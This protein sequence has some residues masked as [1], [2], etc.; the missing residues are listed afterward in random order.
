M[1]SYHQ[2]R[3]MLVG[4]LYLFC[5]SLKISGLLMDVYGVPVVKNLPCN[6]GDTGLI[7]GWGNRSHMPPGMDKNK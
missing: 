7:L 6:V 3:L 2:S 4:V 1:N 5:Y